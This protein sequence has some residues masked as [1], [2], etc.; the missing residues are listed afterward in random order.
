MIIDKCIEIEI[1]RYNRKTYKKLTDKKLE[2]GDIIFVNQMDLPSGSRIPVSCE[3]DMCG[4]IF[5]KERY[6]I[7][8]KVTL[9]GKKCR[10]EY[11]KTLNPSL[12]IKNIIK[13]CEVC[14][15]IM[16]IHPSKLKRQ[17]HFLCS[18]NCYR[19][20]RSKTYRG[21]NV[22]NY[23]DIKIECEYC[24]KLFKTINYDLK[25]NKHLFCSQECYWAFRKE[26]YKEEYYDDRLN[27][28]RKETV[29]EREVRKYLE[30]NNIKFEQEKPMFRK[31]YVDFYLNDFG[32]IIEVNG[33][34]W[35]ANPKFYG[36]GKKPFDKIQLRQIKRDKERYEYI[37]QK[38]FKVFVIWENQ[39]KTDLEYYM[40]GILDQLLAI[41][42]TP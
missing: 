1:N 6:N 23:Q 39:I 38:G 11:L 29:P 42:K 21:K 4:K 30:K 37:K 27:K 28:D 40:R 15:K 20:H 32:T 14:G 13:R 12:K 18:V 33:D 2:Y 26:H 25:T 19:K 9:C 41:N 34:Y 31:Y 24:G 7:K 36:D 17:K 16:E 35:H 22:Y 5:E 10:N 3:C 8:G